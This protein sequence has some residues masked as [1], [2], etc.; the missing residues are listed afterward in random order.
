MLEAAAGVE[1]SLGFYPIPAADPRAVY[2]RYLTL[3]NAVR[4]VSFVGR[5]ATYRYHSMDQVV[6]MALAEAAR[7]LHRHGSQAS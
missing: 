7:L 4:N 6:G 3:A 1:R 5:L 2:Q